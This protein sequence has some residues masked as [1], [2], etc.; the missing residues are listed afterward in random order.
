MQVH[1]DAESN[2]LTLD[3]AGGEIAYAK[4]VN[5]VVLHF[6]ASHVPVLIEILEATHLF[7]KI[8]F[9]RKGAGPAIEPAPTGAGT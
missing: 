6:T 5:G 3:I 7:R 9:N 1:Y 2:I 4:E 8:A